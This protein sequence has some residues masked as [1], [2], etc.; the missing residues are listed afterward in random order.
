MVDP[1]MDLGMADY[2]EHPMT[3]PFDLE[4]LQF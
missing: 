2:S 4:P 3:R 1:A